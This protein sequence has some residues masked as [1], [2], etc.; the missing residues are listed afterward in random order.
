M[1]GPKTNH[2]VKNKLNAEM[3]KVAKTSL[4]DYGSCN[5]HL[6]H[7]GFKKGLK[8]Y[9]YSAADL[10]TQTFNWFDGHPVRREKFKVICEKKQIEYKCLIKHVESRWITLLDAAERF[11]YLLPAI[12][13]YFAEMN[14]KENKGIH[15]NNISRHL[16]ATGAN[17]V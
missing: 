16:K 3:Q 1:D 7:N 11:Q 12:R 4:L 17:D 15:Y 14:K 6:A 10:I 8:V 5:L 13:S 9:G 2:S